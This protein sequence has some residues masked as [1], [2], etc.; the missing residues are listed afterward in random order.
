[1]TVIQAV[2]VSSKSIGVEWLKFSLHVVSRFKFPASR[3]PR[4][5][6]SSSHPVAETGPY[7]R[8]DNAWTHSDDVSCDCPRLTLGGTYLLVGSMQ[9]QPSGGHSGLVL[10]RDSVVMPWRSSWSRRLKRL[11]RYQ[12]RGGC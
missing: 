1:M 2:V 6:S 3:E 12:Q 11:A 10:G 4:S 5:S 7:R 9:R 8:L